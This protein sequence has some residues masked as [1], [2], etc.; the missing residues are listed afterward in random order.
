MKQ[1]CFNCKHYSHEDNTDGYCTYH[2]DWLGKDD[3]LDPNCRC[4]AWDWDAEYDD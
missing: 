1:C 2:Q 3:V 4:P